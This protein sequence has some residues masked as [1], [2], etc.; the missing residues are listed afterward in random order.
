MLPIVAVARLPKFDIGPKSVNNER[1]KQ[2]ISID[3]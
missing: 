3:L 2:V 1:L